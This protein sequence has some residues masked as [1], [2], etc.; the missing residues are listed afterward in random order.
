MC[1]F[2]KIWPAFQ[3]NELVN[4]GYSNDSVLTF[5]RCTVENDLQT[6]SSRVTL[7]GRYNTFYSF[8]YLTAEADSLVKLLEIT[9][10]ATVT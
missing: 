3:K 1:Q 6:S 4:L 7:G 2:V 10:T 5:A 9:I 8:L